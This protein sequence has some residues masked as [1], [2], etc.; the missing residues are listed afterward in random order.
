MDEHDPTGVQAPEGRARLVLALSAG[1]GALVSLA[2]SVV[3]IASPRISERLDADLTD[4]NLVTN[5]LFLPLVALLVLGGLSADRW[6]RRP[7]FVFGLSLIALGVVGSISAPSVGVLIA[8][9]LVEGIGAAF[10]LPTSVA[11]LRTMYGGAALL[12]A[13]SIWVG[14]TVGGAAVGPI[15]GGLLLQVGDWRLVFLPELLMVIA[16]MVVAGIALRGPA[17]AQRGA[18]ELHVP[19]NIALFAGLLLATFGLVTVGQGGSPAIT[20]GA[21]AV[22]VVLLLGVAM[23]AGWLVGTDAQPGS[24]R[25]LGVGIVVAVSGLFAVTGVFF[26]SAIYLQ[27]D[28]GFTPFQA[29]LALLPQT[30]LGAV[31]AFGGGRVI[32]RF[33][34]R[35]SVVAA[36]AIEALG[37]IALLR[38]D[39]DSTYV[40][41]LPAQVTI[42]V[43]V[44][45]VPTASLAIVLRS[46]PASQGGVLAGV[47]SS[48]L[49]L[50]N[51]LSIAVLSLAVAISMPARFEQVLPAAVAKA[52]PEVAGARLAVGPNPAMDDADQRVRADVARAQRDAFA[53]SFG[54]AGLI[55]GSV[56][57]LGMAASW[58]VLRDPED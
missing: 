20:I 46:G 5:A 2:Q 33:G 45:V 11:L 8:A 53:H 51:L 18:V 25:R 58:R 57:L 41:L 37:M 10:A 42:A 56:A 34:L 14:F 39:A 12:R 3:P 17:F 47:Q 9:R 21:L 6:G 13:L 35:R 28:L 55:A 49:N 50:G 24:M 16:G 43:I 32:T 19:W 38:L 31:F 54:I 22:G 36:F 1:T 48:A 52:V 7:V 40:D 15:L 44:A 23:R 29:A 27:R 4:L 30:G 26:L